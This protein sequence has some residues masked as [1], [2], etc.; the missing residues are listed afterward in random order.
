MTPWFQTVGK[1][2][3]TKGRRVTFKENIPAGEVSKDATCT[4]SYSVRLRFDGG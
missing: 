3:M 4:F 1:D 2:E